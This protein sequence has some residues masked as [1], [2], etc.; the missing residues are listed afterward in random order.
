MSKSVKVTMLYQDANTR[1]YSFNASNSI[2]PNAVRE[3]IT[4]INA[5]IAGGTDGGFSQT[6]VS[7]EGSNLTK[8]S[9]A[10]VIT[11]VDTII[12]GGDF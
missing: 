2:T 11:E 5:S 1:D 10:S 4:A 12:F 9:G 6:F 8:I 7:D 3:K